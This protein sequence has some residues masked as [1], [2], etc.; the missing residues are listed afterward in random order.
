[1]GLSFVARLALLLAIAGTLSWID[2][3]R[4]GAASTARYEYGFIL[5]TG[6]LGAMLGGINDAMTSAL[7]PAYFTR[8]KGLAEGP[9]LHAAAILYGAQVGCSGGVVSGAILVYAA[10]R[11]SRRLPLE[12][13]WLLR[14]IWIPLA[15]AALG[16][17]IG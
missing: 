12:F 14:R 7:S 5:L 8:G 16:G 15:A 10:R 13:G 4:R 6:L 17:F 9:R 2:F 3:R 1:M 11:K